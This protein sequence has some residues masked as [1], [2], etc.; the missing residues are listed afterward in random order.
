[1]SIAIRHHRLL[2]EEAA[3]KLYSNPHVRIEP[4]GT[5]RP[6]EEYRIVFLCPGVLDPEMTIGREHVVRLTIPGGYPEHA[7]SIHVQTPI[8]HPNVF[9]T[10]NVCMGKLWS[11]T[12]EL[13]Q[14][15]AEVGRIIEYQNFSVDDRANGE[16]SS[17]QWNAWLD[18][19]KQRHGLPLGQTVFTDLSDA[20]PDPKIE[21]SLRGPAP[22]PDTS[23]PPTTAE[24][25]LIV[26]TRR[27]V[28]APQRP[29][30]SGVHEIQIIP[31]VTSDIVVRRR[32][33]DEDGHI[34]IRRR[35]DSGGAARP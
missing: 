28:D 13:Q 23:R 19:L 16:L 10:G 27:L 29:Q 31:R 25:D 35:D 33:G 5:R 8:W 7:P 24:P 4:A 18:T 22:R 30:P 20:A 17:S 21:V 12:L 2:E 3:L 32:E 1:M 26:V 6:V 15:I 9:D 14:Y 34:I 11:P